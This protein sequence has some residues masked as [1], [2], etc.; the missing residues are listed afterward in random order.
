MR[1]NGRT[2]ALWQLYVMALVAQ[3]PMEP[4]APLRCDAAQ[5]STGHHLCM[6]V[7]CHTR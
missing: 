4:G 6:R 5:S 7:T 3:A 2:V 1:Q